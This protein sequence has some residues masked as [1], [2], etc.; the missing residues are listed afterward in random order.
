MFPSI[1]SPRDP[2][3]H[4]AWGSSH[5]RLGLGQRGQNQQQPLSLLLLCGK[6]ACEE[7]RTRYVVCKAP[8]PWESLFSI[9]KFLLWSGN[10]HG[11]SLLYKGDFFFFFLI[12]SAGWNQKKWAAT[13][14]FNLLFS[15][16]KKKKNPENGQS[17]PSAHT[18][19]LLSI[20]LVK[21][22]S[23]KLN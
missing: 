13:C 8:I 7:A 14:I 3:G 23:K 1:R 22:R 4:P 9:Q 2:G 21:F 18:W 12:F 5:R 16:P 17:D 6:E 10:F 15:H 20:S 19:V 11:M